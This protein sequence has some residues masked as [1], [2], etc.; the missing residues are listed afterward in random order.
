MAALA[1][2]VVNR[3][4]SRQAS[5]RGQRLSPKRMNSALQSKLG[6]QG[7]GCEAERSYFNTQTRRHRGRVEAGSQ[8]LTVPARY[9]SKSHQ[10]G[11]RKTRKAREAGDCRRS[12]SD[13]KHG[14]RQTATAAPR[15]R[16]TCALSRPLS[17]LAARNLKTRRGSVSTGRSKS[18]VRHRPLFVIIRSIGEIR[19]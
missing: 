15:L 14:P 11:P 9:G 4:S 16:A 8:G 5:R 10:V 3:R 13:R 2:G 6:N 18:S 19:G 12:R 1:E 17:W 7:G